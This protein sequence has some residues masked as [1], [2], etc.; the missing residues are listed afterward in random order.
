M[1]R[2]I[3]EK[4]LWINSNNQEL[5]YSL[6]GTAT[7]T[8]STNN[9]YYNIGNNLYVDNYKKLSV[10]MIDCAVSKFYHEY[11]IGTTGINTYA[12]IP[13]YTSVIKVYINFNV[14]SNSIYNDGNGLLM[15]VISD[16]NI[17]VRLGTTDQMNELYYT[18]LGC[19]KL[20]NDNK[21]KYFLKDVPTGIININVY[22]ELNN[23]LL[24]YE[25][26]APSNVMFKIYI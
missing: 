5:F 14:V 13:F 26:N 24:D 17:N 25:N 6:N 8:A 18:G 20:G 21:I 10:E 7:Y 2:K 11:A 3:Q 9:F 4:I 16:T 1:E 23:V 19:A 15:G 22:N 12:P